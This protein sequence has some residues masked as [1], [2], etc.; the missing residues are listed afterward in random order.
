[1]NA[2]TI[3]NLFKVIELDRCDADVKVLQTNVPFRFN[4]IESRVGF[5]LHY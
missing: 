1:M 2:I 3:C 4:F 5:R